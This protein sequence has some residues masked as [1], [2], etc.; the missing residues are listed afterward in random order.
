MDGKEGMGAKGME[1]EEKHGQS[2]QKKGDHDFS[3]I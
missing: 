3:K 1:E 2:G